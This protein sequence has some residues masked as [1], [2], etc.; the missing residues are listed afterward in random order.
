[1]RN[2]ILTTFLLFFVITTSVFARTTE[3]CATIDGSGSMDA[4]E[5][6]LQTDG[7]ASAIENP[8]VVPQDGT[9]TFSLVQFSSSARV[10]IT[11]TRID[12]QA[13]ANWIAGKIRAISQLSGGTNIPSAIDLCSQQFKFNSDKQVIDISTDGENTEGGSPSVASDRS[14][15]RGVDVINALGI[16]DSID[17]T[18]LKSMVR[19]QPAHIFPQDGFVLVTPSFIE[20]AN[21]IK[22]KL[23]AET[24]TFIPATGSVELCAAIDGSGSMESQD[25]TIQKEGLA[26]AI[27][28]P[29]VVPTDGRVTFSL[30]QFSSTARIEI[31]PTLIDSQTTATAVAAKIRAISQLGSATNIPSAINLCA[32]QFKFTANKQLIDISTD[33]ENTDGGSPSTAADNAM[34]K[35]VDVINALGVGSGIKQDELKLLVRPQPAKNFPE[36]GFVYLVSDFASYANAIKEKMSAETGTRIPGT[37]VTQDLRIRAMIQTVEKG[38]IEGVWRLGGDAKTNRGDRVIWGYFYASPNDVTWGDE[39]NPDLFVKVWF[40]VGGRTD[41]N[42]FHVSVPNIEVQSTKGNKYPLQGTTTMGVRYVRHSF[43]DDGSQQAFSVPTLDT[44]ASKSVSRS[45]N[46]NIGIAESTK[47]N[48]VEKGLIIG[49]GGN[50]DIGN[51]VRGDRVRWGYYYADPNQVSWGDPNNPDVFYKIW[52]D[53]S[54]RIDVNFFHVSVPD[55]EVFSQ[56]VDLAANIP[57]TELFK[58][59]S[60]LNMRYVRH[61]YSAPDNVEGF[62]RDA[63]TGTPLANVSVKVSQQGSQIDQIFSGTDGRYRLNI[64]EGE[65]TLDVSLMG[66]IPATVIIKVVRGE[67]L[68]VTALRQVSQANAGS[69]T[70]AGFISNAFNGQSVDSIT[71][72]V[73]NGVNVKTGAIVA[74]AITKSDGSYSVNL[75]GG[76]YTIELSGTGYLNTYFD[77]TCVGGYTANNQNASITPT[78]GSGEIRVVLTWGDKPDDLDSHLITPNVQGRSYH[79][80]FDYGGDRNVAPYVLLDVD[81]VSSYGP[82]T[83][84]IYQS[85]PGIYR[86]AVHDFTAFDSNSTPTI[87]SSSA[88]VDVY[89]STGLLKSYKVPSTGAGRCWE[90]FSL[91]GVTGEMTTI[92]RISPTEPCESVFQPAD[93]CLTVQRYN[94]PE[95]RLFESAFTK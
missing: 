95:E 92:N 34:A 24:G 63:V 30:V 8:T 15:T 52:F 4:D 91:N 37:L 62:V 46:A 66:Y 82:E 73:R 35:G 87:T 13:T 47:I 40:D 61:E 75:P 28:D 83:I 84:T 48:T 74:T 10:E 18:Q 90:V 9:V 51:P 70:V 12:G 79:L 44:S 54:G 56:M 69:G 78:I 53:V 77:I 68:T 16:G 2:L 3:I 42:Y 94:S 89:S 1:M 36:D 43:N 49:K 20:Y 81:D 39:N 33:G 21:A 67:N 7:L 64:P 31:A 76:N 71:L 45:A 50:G 6:K 27:E 17:Q 41:V 86:Y 80:F 93:S 65:Y 59:T 22:S 29:S 55:I 25:F 26:S 5:F 88:K 38:Q 58:S 23:A 14:I 60:S 72:K 19:P 85:K 57:M 11:P 32:S